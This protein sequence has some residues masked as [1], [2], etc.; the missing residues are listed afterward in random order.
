VLGLVLLAGDDWG[1][2]A[3]SVGIVAGIL[4]A[5]VLLVTGLRAF[6]GMGASDNPLRLRQFV[7]AGILAALL[8]VILGAGIGLVAPLH[9]AEA[10]TF[11]AQHEW[12]H[13][14][15]EYT[16][17]GERAPG[18]ND[19][20]RVYNEWG[21]Q[22][23][24]GGQYAAI[25]K[26]GVVLGSYAGAAAQVARAQAGLIAAY[27]AWAQ[28]AAQQQA[29]A[30]AARYL[31]T[32]LT[33]PYCASRLRIQIAHPDCASSCQSRAPRSMPLPITTSLRP[34]WRAATSVER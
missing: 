8:L 5:L 31:D 2:G 14:I 25:D 9:R 17:A 15:T 6:A 23:S 1:D 7:S 24:A 16:L 34:N 12:Q 13:A 11:E 32:L 29:Y 22:L 18:S 26:F 33:L 20:A 3:R 28:Q 21:E 4:F 27:L 30:S 10:G 19:L